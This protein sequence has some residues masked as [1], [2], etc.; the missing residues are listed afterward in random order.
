MT[1][2]QHIVQCYVFLR[3]YCQWKKIARR[4]KNTDFHKS[5][6]P[7]LVIVPCDPWS[8]GGSRGDE[9]MIMGVIDRY[10][11]LNP[12]IPIHIVCADEGVHY[13][14]QLNIKDITP[15]SCWNGAY[16]IENIYQSIISTNPSDVVILG[17]DCMDGYYSPILSLQLLSIHDLCNKTS[18][19]HSRLL[20]FS[21]NA[22]PSWLMIRAFKSLSSDTKLQIRDPLSYE[23]FQKK[24]NRSAKLVAD[25]A[26]M[27][28]PR[29]NFPLYKTIKKW[30]DDQRTLGRTII[31]LNFHPMLR[32]YDDPEDIKG[33]A[34][35]LA[36]NVEAI[37]QKHHNVSFILMPHD[38]R[39]GITDN[40]MLSNIYNYLQKSGQITNQVFYSAEV[41]RAA[42]LKALCGLIDG[43][44]SS[45][46]HLAIA[47]LGMKVPVMAATYQ[48]KFEGLFQHFGL[49][50]SYLLDAKQFLSN[51]MIVT[52]ENFLKELPI[53]K[54]HISERLTKVQTLSNANFED[55]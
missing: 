48:D 14:Q 8:V 28:H 37:L 40:L 34:M 25:A 45:R 29:P 22:H 20:G 33:D 38:D 5:T 35:L 3:S 2:R 21:F 30:T 52:F 18:H 41:P 50:D 42:Q 11:R 6:T 54:Q 49:D 24:V 32:T 13:I 27:L 53:L 51:K 23:R 17:A 31:G 39:K 10:R 43:L 12:D 15:I 36:K 44:I 26:F 4:V 1:I 19:L 16:S 55:E 7:S 47:A 46:M 9:A